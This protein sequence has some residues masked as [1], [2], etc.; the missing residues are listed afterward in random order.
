MGMR[1]PINYDDTIR[2]LNTLQACW[3][4][5][6][7]HLCYLTDLSYHLPGSLDD[8]GHEASMCQNND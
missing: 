2:E 8:G 5:S 3:P 4:K 6:F 1:R 7:F